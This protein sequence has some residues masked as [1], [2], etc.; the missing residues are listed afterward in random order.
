M[1][2][3]FL[4]ICYFKKLR[5]K[6]FNYIPKKKTNPS[7][8]RCLHDLGYTHLFRSQGS[9]ERSQSTSILHRK[10]AVCQCL[11]HP[12]RWSV[13]G[14]RSKALTSLAAKASLVLSDVPKK[15]RH[16]VESF[17]F[18][19]NRIHPRG[20]NSETFNGKDWCLALLTSSNV[21]QTCYP[22]TAPSRHDPAPPVQQELRN[23]APQG[24]V[25]V[26]TKLTLTYLL[27]SIYIYIIYNFHRFLNSGLLHVTVSKNQIQYNNVCIISASWY[28]MH[29]QFSET[30]PFWTG[31]PT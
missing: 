12:D 17:D 5:K 10:N 28:S 19:P 4:H 11:E 9:K 30:V 6:S 26:D 14:R 25:D 20:E 24:R 31:S 8:G 16:P 21:H 15:K 2:C 22:Q 1:P 3:H 18:Q 7:P 29:F 13:T 23:I 27:V